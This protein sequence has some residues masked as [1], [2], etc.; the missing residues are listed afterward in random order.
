MIFVSRDA[1]SRMIRPA[2]ASPK[3]A[4]SPMFQTIEAHSPLPKGLLIHTHGSAARCHRKA[5]NADVNEVSAII[6]F[7]PASNE[8]PHVPHHF[9]GVIF[10]PSPE[11]C[12]PIVVESFS[13]PP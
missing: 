2:E 10:N 7:A 3:T 9:R 6:K 13:M 1:A 4:V 11:T 8:R 5:D 12:L